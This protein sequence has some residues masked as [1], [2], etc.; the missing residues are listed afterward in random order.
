MD[1]AFRHPSLS[2]FHVFKLS[3]FVSLCRQ[4]KPSIQQGWREQGRDENLPINVAEYLASQLKMTNEEVNLCWSLLSQEAM[5]GE[6]HPL[7]PLMPTLST[8][9]ES[10]E[11]LKTL[12]LREKVDLFS[13]IRS[14]E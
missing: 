13:I 6:D 7:Q 9:Q 8:T 4:L 12:N 1:D 11:K 3:G 14:D 2:Q 5:S 10:V